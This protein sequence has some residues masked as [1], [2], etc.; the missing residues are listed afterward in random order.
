MKDI[1]TIYSQGFVKWA[2]DKGGS[3]IPLIV[4]SAKTNGTGLLNPSVFYDKGNI[5][6]VIRHVNYTLFH[7]EGKLF[8]HRFGPLQYI[9]PDQDRTL[10]TTNYLCEMNNSYDILSINKIST[11]LFDEDPM[12]HFIGLEDAR[13]VKWNDKL[14]LSGVRRD[15]TDNG[16]GR[17]ELSSIIVSK[18]G[19]VAEVSRERIPTPYGTDS[20]CE[21]NWMP[22]L[23]KPYHY[24]KWTNPTEIAIYDPETLLTSNIVKEKTFPL[25]YDLRGGTQVVPIG[26]KYYAIVHDVDLFQSEGGSKDAIYR[27][28]IVRWNKDF[29]LEFISDRFHFMNG[30]VEFCSGMA[31]HGGNLLVSFGFQD[32]A[33]YL[34]VLPLK[35]FTNE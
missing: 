13:L 18:Q 17:M 35:S 6:I 28:R 12:W 14:Y 4:P 2:F 31:V 23:D 15:T 1:N 26:D 29:D 9:H 7:S 19:K 16:V 30:H 20:Y 24:V 25:F 33:A 11:D 27:H 5:M 3:I 21:K 10:T 34:V 22:V 32:N 8:Q